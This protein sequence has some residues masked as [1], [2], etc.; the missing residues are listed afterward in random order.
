MS[1]QRD[2]TRIRAAA[3]PSVVWVLAP[4]AL[5]NLRPR[6]LHGVLQVDAL[7]NQQLGAGPDVREGVS[8]FLEKRNPVFPGKVSADMPPAYPWWDQI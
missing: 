6:L 8:A 3:L 5:A 4:V 1:A 2:S 7:L